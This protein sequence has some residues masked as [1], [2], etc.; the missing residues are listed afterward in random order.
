LES[1]RGLFR[2]AGRTQ[3]DGPQPVPMPIEQ[4]AE[5]LGIAIDVPGHEGA[6][7]CV[8]TRALL[9]ATTCAHPLLPRT[10]RARFAGPKRYEKI[11]TFARLSR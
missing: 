9:L 10:V 6:V 8:V 3:R 7:G 1:I 11:L 5:C 4:L 2:I